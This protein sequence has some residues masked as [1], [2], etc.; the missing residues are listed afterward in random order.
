MLDTKKAPLGAC[1]SEG[2]SPNLSHDPLSS[3][4]ETG[5]LCASHVC[6]RGVSDAWAFSACRGRLQLARLCPRD[7]SSSTFDVQSTPKYL[8]ASAAITLYQ[9]PG[10]KRNQQTRLP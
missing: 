4:L 7:V 8:F 10:T 9:A 5:S 3:F 6:E 1:D 2:Y